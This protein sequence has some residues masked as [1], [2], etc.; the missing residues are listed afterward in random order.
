M[1]FTAL[2]THHNKAQLDI[3]P[4]NAIELMCANHS[5]QKQKLFS[6]NRVNYTSRH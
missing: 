4:V 1:S 3:N 5:Q 6:F 2:E